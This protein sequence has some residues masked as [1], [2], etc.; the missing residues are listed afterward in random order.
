MAWSERLFSIYTGST[1]TS[2]VHHA[3]KHSKLTVTYASGK[4]F[5]K[6]FEVKQVIV[7]DVGVG[8]RFIQPIDTLKQGILRVE[9]LQ[10]QQVKELP[11][12][13]IKNGCNH[14]KFTDIMQAHLAMPPVSI[15]GSF[16]NLTLII[17]LK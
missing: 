9:T 15:P 8:I 14:N 7:V 16:P 10:D 1:Y 6:K 12:D 2:I 17:R 4:H 11:N 3:I 5:P 13:T